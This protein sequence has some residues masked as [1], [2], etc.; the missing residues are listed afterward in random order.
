MSYQEKKTVVSV[1]TG[2]LVLAAYGIYALSSMPS[3]SPDDL[4][5]WAGAILLFIGIGIVASIVIQIVFHILLSIGHAIRE[6]LDNGAC[7]DK[8]IEKAIEQDMV[9]DEMDKLIS[10][11]SMRI[12]F[13]VAGGGFVAALI[14]VVLNFSAAVMLN[15]MF[16]SFSISVIIEGITQLRFYKKGVKHG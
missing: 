15:V 7:D 1:C 16:V 8:E 4:K 10:L 6:K 14:A 5:F 2:I 9:E 3:V 12:G 13:A 11:K